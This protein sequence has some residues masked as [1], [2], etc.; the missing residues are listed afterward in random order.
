MNKAVNLLQQYI[1][2]GQLE[3]ALMECKKIV[4]LNPK[5]IYLMKLLSHIYFLK[6]DYPAAINETF[7]ILKISPDDFDSF[8]NLGNYYLKQE[9]YEKALDNI[10]KAKTWTTTTCE[11][12]DIF[13]WYV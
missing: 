8:N 12:V 11:A 7:N 1:S 2:D 13:S 10:T 6:D 4:K 5:D 3:K 9:E